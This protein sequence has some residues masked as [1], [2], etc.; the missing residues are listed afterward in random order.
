MIRDKGMIG[1]GGSSMD[2]WICVVGISMVDNRSSMIRSGMVNRGGMVGS[3]GISSTMGN[4]NRCMYSSS[5]LISIMIG[6][7]SLR[8]SILFEIKR[9]LVYNS[10]SFKLTDLFI[11]YSF[12]QNVYANKKF[13]SNKRL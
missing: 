11:L 3:R 8:N 9:V 2:N 13:I 10:T 6:I 12:I 7:N 5:I 4:S 1:S